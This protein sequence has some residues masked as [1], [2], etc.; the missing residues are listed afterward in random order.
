[1][2]AALSKIE[3]ELNGRI[4]RMVQKCWDLTGKYLP[5]EVMVE[6]RGDELLM[7]EMMVDD[8]VACGMD[9]E[10]WLVRNTG[11]GMTT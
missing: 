9:L 2:G 7:M 4:H 10:R 11:R 6:G 5:V 1:V 8:S 3:A